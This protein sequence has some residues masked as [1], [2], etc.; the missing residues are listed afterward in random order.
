MPA[1]GTIAIKVSNNYEICREKSHS[2]YLLDAQIKRVH[3]FSISSRFAAKALGGPVLV[4][5]L[6]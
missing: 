4:A 1:I 6:A 3:T 2:D 5:K